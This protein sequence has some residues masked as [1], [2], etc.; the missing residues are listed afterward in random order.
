MPLIREDEFL[1]FIDYINDATIP[2]TDKKEIEPYVLQ[3]EKQQKEL[4]LTLTPKLDMQVMSEQEKARDTMD[5]MYGGNAIDVEIPNNVKSLYTDDESRAQ[6][7]NLQ[8]FKMR[9]GKDITPQEYPLYRNDFY[10]KEFAGIEPPA[11]DLETFGQIKQIFDK[12]RAEEKVI[13]DNFKFAIA[14]IAEDES[15]EATIERLK[16]QNDA[17]FDINKFTEA[18]NKM[19]N[20]IKVYKPDM[21]NFTAAMSRKMTGESTEQ[22]Q[23]IIDNFAKIIND[24]PDSHRSLVLTSLHKESAKLGVADAKTRNNVFNE[25]ADSFGRIFTSGAVGLGEAVEEGIYKKIPTRGKVTTTI[26]TIASIADAE[27]YVAEQFTQGLKD[28][29]ASTR[30]EGPGFAPSIAGGVERELSADEDLYIKKVLKDSRKNVQV[31]R[32]ITAIGQSLDPIRDN[33]KG[34]MASTLGSSAGLLG[35]SM[36]GPSGPFVAA[37]MYR[38]MNYTEI[39]RENPDM[40]PGA[41]DLLAATSGAFEAALDKV[42]IGLFKKFPKFYGALTKTG[43]STSSKVLKGLGLAATTY[44]LEQVIEGAQDISV[45]ATQQV[46]SML[47]DAVPEV[48]WSEKLD[49]WK[50]TRLDVAIG[51]IPLTVAGAGISSVSKYVSDKNILSI[52]SD[53]ETMMDYGI[54]ESDRL[55]LTRLAEQKDVDAIRNLLP[56]ATQRFDAELRAQRVAEKSMQQMLAVDS[57]AALNEAIQAGAIPQFDLNADGTYTAT[58]PAGQKVTLNNRNE[59]TTFINSRIDDAVKGKQLIINNGTA[60]VAKTANSIMMPNSLEEAEQ[61]NTSVARLKGASA[62]AVRANNAAFGDKVQQNRVFQ[63]AVK[64]LFSGKKNSN[65]IV[66]EYVNGIYRNLPE[67]TRNALGAD[68]IDGKRNLAGIVTG[69]QIPQAKRPGISIPAA[70]IKSTIKQIDVDL[71]PPNIQGALQRYTNEFRNANI[72]Y[73]GS[74]GDFNVVFGELQPTTDATQQEIDNVN[75]VNDFIAKFSN[76]FGVKIVFSNTLDSQGNVLPANTVVSPYNGAFRPGANIIILDARSTGVSL[77]VVVGHEFGHFIQ[78][79][80]AP[81]YKQ[82]TDSIRS[83]LDKT[84]AARQLWINAAAKLHNSYFEGNKDAYI[85]AINDGIAFDRTQTIISP[86]ADER[87]ESE[88][89]NDVIGNLFTDAK[90]WQEIYNATQDK[91]LIEKLYDSVVK[92]LDFVNE[93]V[94][95]RQ[96]MS[97]VAFRINRMFTAKG[98]EQLSIITE[99]LVAQLQ[100]QVSGLI[101]QARVTQ[102]GAAADAEMLASVTQQNMT[103]APNADVEHVAN[104]I[105]DTVALAQVAAQQAKQRGEQ[106]TGAAAEEADVEATLAEIIAPIDAASFDA[107]ATQRAEIRNSVRMRNSLRKALF[108][109]DVSLNALANAAAVV[110]GTY[111]DV[112]NLTDVEKLEYISKA[113]EKVDEYFKLAEMDR[114]RGMSAAFSQ[115]A[116]NVRATNPQGAKFADY[117][118]QALEMDNAPEQAAALFDKL[119][120]ADGIPVAKDIE[121]YADNLLRYNIIKTV[122]NWRNMTSDQLQMM[123]NQLI[124]II[125]APMAKSNEFLRSLQNSISYIRE[126]ARTSNSLSKREQSMFNKM[127]AP[128]NPILKGAKK[129]LQPLVDMMGSF[130][131]SHL[132]FASLVELVFPNN[133]NA[134]ATVY[135]QIEALQNTINDP[136]ADESTKEAAQYELTQKQK[137]IGK[138]ITP[139]MQKIVDDVRNSYTQ[140]LIDNETNEDA[141]RNTIAR[142]FGLK[143]PSAMKVNRVLYDLMD[144]TVAPGKAFFVTING[145]EYSLSQSYAAYIL[146]LQE[147]RMYDAQLVANGFTAQVL[148]DIRSKISKEANALRIELRKNIIKEHKKASDMSLKTFGIGTVVPPDV[149]FPVQRKSTP[150]ALVDAFDVNFQG[151]ITNQDMSQVL[152]QDEQ[153]ELD[154]NEQAINLLSMYN[155]HMYLSTFQRNVKAPVSKAK[156]VLLDKVIADKITNA[157]GNDFYNQLYKLLNGLETNGV[158]STE[159]NRT[160]RR[161]MRGFM[162]AFAKGALALNPTTILLNMT[163]FFN[164]ALDASIPANKMMMSYVK[165]VASLMTA[166]QMGAGLKMSPKQIRQMAI[167][168]Q[169]IK[170]GANNL[171]AISKTD[172]SVDKPGAI[173]AAGDFGL[174][175]I[176]MAD[177]FMGSIAAAVAYDAHYK[178]AKEAKMSDADAAIA[179]EQGMKRTIQSTFQPNTVA[180]KSTV[181]MNSNVVMRMLGMF[182]SEARKAVG[183]EITA[184]KKGAN[185]LGWSEFL[186]IAAVNHF[187]IGGLSFFIRAGITD[188]LNDEEEDEDIWNPAELAKSIMVGPLAGLFMIGAAAET[189]ASKTLNFLIETSDWDEDGEIKKLPSFPRD[190]MFAQTANQMMRVTDL[191][192][193]D[194]ELTPDESADRIINAGKALSAVLNNNFMAGATTLAK[195]GKSL[196][197]F[198]DENVTD[199]MEEPEQ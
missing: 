195:A 14:S 49:Q 145:R 177:G 52:A 51:M 45:D 91:T 80:N 78:K 164:T 130:S 82:I 40:D 90:T 146:N 128:M 139:E 4:G 58:T 13:E 135:K 42:S 43:G 64:D 96:A 182:M 120:T 199:I 33:W 162:G 151:G 34:L 123:T 79:N 152:G 114:M 173:S 108:N 17:S 131:D 65:K 133:A 30:P 22:D 125:N 1:Q 11:S 142:I 70:R 129:I 179:A 190:N 185:G 85:K 118:A 88:I 59:V 124:D 37:N 76:Y 50:D 191:L 136:N 150:S 117:L 31:K 180:G 86:D 107:A 92:F 10:N 54:I 105:R 29:A 138:A 100:K 24:M 197:D 165:G 143:K 116:D 41:A 47:T 154:L 122:A 84:N 155:S 175:P 2:E 184:F 27:K 23:A 3:Y 134:T 172:P 161:Y 141:M 102:A 156:A 25:F 127:N 66:E 158:R 35:V 159:M 16:T 67:S 7:A 62:N 167:I 61:Q 98:Q 178:M 112:A 163:S 193:Q 21:N 176:S 119:Y 111:A 121:E 57:A 9:Y 63:Q 157:F 56:Q 55:E 194:K 196:V 5:S 166:G 198:I 44:G 77:A 18:Y 171:L 12:Q 46:M 170:G 126:E 132:T 39:M 87:I 94:L 19:S 81:L 75:A 53:V 113:L 99:D 8:Y 153:I 97:S 60:D 69:M 71:L 140:V 186:R 104:K 6:Y 103:S 72:R 83:M 187:I 74:R 149:F 148:A 73:L 160:W 137:L 183:L 26:P 174:R 32:E 38:G 20:I 36:M 95:G 168:Q 28:Y 115:F 89:I 48:N 147:S 110:D 144:R 109:G 101:A 192:D 106:R 188:L 181:E 169:R 15:S 93:T 68:E 189:V